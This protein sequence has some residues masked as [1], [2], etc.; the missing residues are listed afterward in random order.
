MNV[1]VRDAIFFLRVFA[2]I[3]DNI[4]KSVQLNFPPGAAAV[5]ADRG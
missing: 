4:P 1:K 3:F 2:L 5:V